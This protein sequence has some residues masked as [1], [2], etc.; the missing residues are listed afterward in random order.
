MVFIQYFHLVLNFL[1][2]FINLKIFEINTE[3]NQKKKDSI[4]IF[5]PIKKLENGLL[6]VKLKTDNVL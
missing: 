5:L 2:S 3:S 4:F 6:K 1:Q